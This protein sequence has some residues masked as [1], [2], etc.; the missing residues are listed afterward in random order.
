MA[1]FFG[2]LSEE[3]R[4]KVYGAAWDKNRKLKQ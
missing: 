3:E 2:S 1:S 4:L